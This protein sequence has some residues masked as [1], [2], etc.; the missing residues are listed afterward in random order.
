MQA[1]N[2]TTP[3][4]PN[5]NAF[6]GQ[7]GLG[8]KVSA[9]KYSGPTSRFLGNISTP[10]I[11]LDNDAQPNRTTWVN[12]VDVGL[13]TK[14]YGAYQVPT[15]D[16]LPTPSCIAKPYIHDSIDKDFGLDT[17]ANKYCAWVTTAREPEADGISPLVTPETPYC[18]KAYPVTGKDGAK[19]MT[20]WLSASIIQ[21]PECGGFMLIESTCKKFFGQ[22]INGCDGDNMEDKY[23]GSFV[24][25]CYVL[26]AQISLMQDGIPPKGKLATQKEG[27]YPY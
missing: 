5:N 17:I 13:Y 3:P 27:F 1:L 12:S 25:S 6:L 11:G 4:M 8:D 18:P 10:W 7:A 2:L 21:H 22:I 9:D 19:D 24:N 26:D 16:A 14:D 23:S 20:L 15:G